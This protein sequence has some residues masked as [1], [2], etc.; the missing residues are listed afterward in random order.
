MVQANNGRDVYLPNKD[1]LKVIL[2]LGCWQGITTQKYADLFPDAIVIGVELLEENFH[3][4]AN[5]LH[6][7]K[8]VQLFNEAVWTYT[9]YVPCTMWA[10]ETSYVRDSRNIRQG[11]NLDL[12]LPC[13]TIDALTIQFDKI[14]FIKFDIEASEHAVLSAGGDWVDK[15]SNV[16]V[17]I[18]DNTNDNVRNLL[19]NLGFKIAK[20]EF[21]R[22]WAYK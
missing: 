12:D 15:T 10:T 1:D 3:I 9:G 17:E 13:T 22:I 19:L 16:F 21:E 7:Y 20:E 4:A 18:H 8:N 14:D 6:E 5:L 11:T 2:D